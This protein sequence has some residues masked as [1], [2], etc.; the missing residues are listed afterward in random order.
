M[1]MV[2]DGANGGWGLAWRFNGR[3]AF[4]KDSDGFYV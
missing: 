1:R 4:L 2:D 3:C